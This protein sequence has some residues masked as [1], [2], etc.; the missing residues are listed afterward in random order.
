[1]KSKCPKF[2]KGGARVDLT[3]Q[4]TKYIIEFFIK[5]FIFKSEGTSNIFDVE[6]PAT[7]DDV[8]INQDA[9][10]QYFKLSFEA[11][12]TLFDDSVP[13]PEIIDF[14]MD[15][16]N[17]YCVRKEP[18][19]QVPETIFL[20]SNDTQMLKVKKKDLPA[21]V[22]HISNIQNEENTETMKQACI[23]EMNK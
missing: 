22:A 15:V 2:V 14:M 16:M 18:V 7:Y 11:L 21:V 1:M 20:K 10:L 9:D 23:D 3:Q 5:R 4:S 12:M 19:G 17:L 8:P 13:H 6:L